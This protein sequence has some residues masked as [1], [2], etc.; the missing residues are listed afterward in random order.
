MT[1]TAI[2]LAQRLRDHTASAHAAAETSPF[3]GR[4]I[5]GEV[6]HRAHL[7]LLV[8]LREV[9]AALDA[10][11]RRLVGT[12]WAGPLDPALDRSAAIEADLQH[13]GTLAPDAP[14]DVLTSTAAYARR[15]AECADTWP[16]GFVAHH[17][18]RLLGDLAG[19]QVIARSLEGRPGLQDGRGTAFFRFEDVGSLPQARA[20][21]RSALDEL[22][23]DGDEATAVADEAIAAF[24]SN[25]ALLAGL[26]ARHGG[27]A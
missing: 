24:A 18:V 15:I 21:Y 22:P 23:L 12:C 17:Y 13:L 19:G 4:L 3:L 16:A 11:R 2:P 7:D 5:S 27:A 10:G 6:G 20:R 9:Y 8:Q 1:T 25:A 26:A 14:R